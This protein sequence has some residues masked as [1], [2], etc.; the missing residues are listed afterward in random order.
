MLLP[1]HEVLSVQEHH[2]GQ[3]TVKCASSTNS[4]WMPELVH[5]FGHRNHQFRAFIISRQT[6]VTP[7][8]KLRTE[9]ASLHRM[10][11][12]A[13]KRWSALTPFSNKADI[14]SLF[15]CAPGWLEIKAFEKS[16]ES[17]A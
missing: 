8:P 2:A 17:Q 10:Q 15:Q 11:R 1:L 6:D 4:L 12:I 16:R 3:L 13:L 14:T 5:G 7:N 9:L